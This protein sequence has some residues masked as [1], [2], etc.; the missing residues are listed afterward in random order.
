MRNMAGKTRRR[1]LAGHPSF[2]R[3]SSNTVRADF[4]E[5]LSAMAAKRYEGICADCE[6]LYLEAAGYEVTLPTERAAELTPAL[7][8]VLKDLDALALV[9]MKRGLDFQLNIESR[10]SH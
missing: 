7:R 4:S 6:E 1:P 2:Q 10:G 8:Q 3:L 5:D 9:V